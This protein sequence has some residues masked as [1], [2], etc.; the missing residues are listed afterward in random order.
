MN[1]YERRMHEV[2]KRYVY[3]EVTPDEYSLPEAIGDSIEE[4]SEETHDS[5]ET[6]EEELQK[7]D[8]RYVRV[9]IKD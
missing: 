6:I 1:N 8:G 3:M 7:I 2:L 9:T 4:L 5:V